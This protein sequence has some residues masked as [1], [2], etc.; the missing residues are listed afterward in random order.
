[1]KPNSSHTLGAT[2]AKKTMSR[3]A[4]YL[5]SALSLWLAGGPTTLPA[6]AGDDAKERFL[7]AYAPACDAL[8][9]RYAKNRRL[10]V[11]EIVYDDGGNVVTRVEHEFLTNDTCILCKTAG[12]KV[13]GGQSRTSSAPPRWTLMRSDHIFAIRSGKNPD[14]YIITE[15][16]PPAVRW[17]D[18]KYPLALMSLPLTYLNLSVA[19]YIRQPS[20]SVLEQSECVW[21]GAPRTR[22][23]VR[24]TKA[25]E[26]WTHWFYFDATDH[27]LLYGVESQ[28]DGAPAKSVAEHFYGQPQDGIAAPV[29]VEGY[30]ER[31]GQRRQPRSLIE[32]GEFT[33][34]KPDDSEFALARFGLPEPAGAREERSGRWHLWLLFAA[35]VIAILAVLTY[36]SVRK[37]E[38]TAV[39]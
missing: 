39:R 11:T 15:M 19:A 35:A 18:A 29:K 5:A 27:W 25:A 23:T 16:G 26:V 6:Y 22:L 24:E 17:E 37:S 8:R 20:V 12:G 30:V 13:V 31:N 34:A 10:R 2:G 32:Y 14:T 36:R 3:M 21:H 4:Y 28:K 7:A 38:R 33:S 9:D 1:M